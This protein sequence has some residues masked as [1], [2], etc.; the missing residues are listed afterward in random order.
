M[1]TILKIFAL[2]LLIF[3]GL[4]TIFG[5]IKTVKEPKDI[6]VAIFA[7]VLFGI[8]PIGGGIL[9]IIK[10]RKRELVIP[11]LLEETE[12]EKE[13]EKV[14]S[15][16]D[17]L[18]LD[19]KGND[20]QESDDSKENS[21]IKENDIILESD[22]VQEAD[23]VK[24]SEIK[25]TVGKRGFLSV[26]IF[27]FTKYS[28]L[29]KEIKSN[30][31]QWKEII[32]RNQNTERKFNEKELHTFGIKLFKGIAYSGQNCHPFRFK[33]ATFSLTEIL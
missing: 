1:K 16:V 25:E 5:T 8:L 20:I 11:S 23:L 13:K 30:N 9:I 33:P 7:I 26:I 14:P 31:Y 2:L 27:F 4:I 21:I 3:G 32:G 15:N 10:Q 29:L 18:K 28:K 24:K 19:Y 12:L 22:N 6:G 17:C